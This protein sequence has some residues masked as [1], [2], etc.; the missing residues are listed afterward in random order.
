M[1]VLKTVP[2]K[3]YVTINHD[4]FRLKLPRQHSLTSL[5]I[6]LEEEEAEVCLHQL[7]LAPFQKP[8]W[9]IKLRSGNNFK[10]KGTL[11]MFIFES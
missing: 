11:F 4:L 1:Q 9:L 2:K 8:S 6:N 5:G 3:V 7:L 10:P